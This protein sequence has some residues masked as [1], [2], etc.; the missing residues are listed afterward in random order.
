VSSFPKGAPS[1]PKVRT[2]KLEA[3]YVQCT[4][5]IE[6]GTKPIAADH[7]ENKLRQRLLNSYPIL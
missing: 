2:K 7:A 1:P 4:Q 5:S 6:P 3:N